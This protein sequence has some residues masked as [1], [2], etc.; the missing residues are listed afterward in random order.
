MYSFARFPFSVPAEI[1]ARS[2]SPAEMCTKSYCKDMSSH[3]VPFPEAGAP[4]II[5]LKGSALF[6][7]ATTTKPG[8][9]ACG[10]LVWRGRG[11]V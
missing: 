6:A 8:V 9:Y 2:K 1:S 5:I 11:R 4:D 3:W 7:D 10:G